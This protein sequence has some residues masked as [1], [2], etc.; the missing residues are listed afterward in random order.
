M[1]H[2]LLPSVSGASLPAKYEAAK[3]AIAACSR[4]DECKAWADQSAALASYAKQADDFEL[5]NTA[6]RIRARAIRRCAKLLGEFKKRQGQRTDLTSY[7]KTTKLNPSEMSYSEASKSLGLT[8]A[9]AITWNRVADIQEETFEAQVESTPAPTISNLAEQGKKKATEKSIPIYEQ[10]G[11]T[12]K[13]FQA[14]MYFRG[15]LK[16]LTTHINE[17][18]S[19]DIIDGSTAEE[20]EDIRQYIKIIDQFNDQLMVKL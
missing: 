18:D 6:K 14:G 10:Q 11:M 15:H 2:A 7:S 13:A 17:Y 8:R 16:T 1:N 3:S 12:K 20:R 19:Q 5:E 9:K 4:V